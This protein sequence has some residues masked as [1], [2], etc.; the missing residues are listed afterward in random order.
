ML[1]LYFG[2]FA[3]AALHV[4]LM[5]GIGT[6]MMVLFLYLFFARGFR[7]FLPKAARLRRG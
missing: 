6:L 7:H 1:F 3:G 5:Q 4:H 2:G